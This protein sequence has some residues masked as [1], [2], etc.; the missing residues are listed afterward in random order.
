MHLLNT[1]VNKQQNMVNKQQE[2]AK[3]VIV[4]PGWLTFEQ[5]KITIPDKSGITVYLHLIVLI[6]TSVKAIYQSR[7]WLRE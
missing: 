4:N 6:N 2:K 3:E 7:K 1:P 5:S